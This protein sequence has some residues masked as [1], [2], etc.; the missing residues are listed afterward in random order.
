MVVLETSWMMSFF[1]SRP[2]NNV[3]ARKDGKYDIIAVWI[4][5]LRSFEIRFEFESTVLIRFES[6]GPI[7]KFLNR[8][9]LSIARRS[10][11]AQTSGTVHRLHASSMS[12]YTPV[13]FNMLQKWN[14]KSVVLVIS[15]VSFVINY[16]LLNARFYSRW[17]RRLQSP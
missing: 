1:P 13:L 11:T 16:W 15:C 14:E 3:K 10:Q 5:D 6:G 17:K 7:R 9:C 4:R 2:T 8:P 12:D